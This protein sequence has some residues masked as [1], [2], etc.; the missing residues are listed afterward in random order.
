MSAYG[1]ADGP[2]EVT[3]EGTFS[4]LDD[5]KHLAFGWASVVELNG[6]PVV[7]RQGDYI[8]PDDIET[9][10]YE[11]VHKSRVGG[12][13]HRRNGEAPH[14]VS[15]LVESI[16]FTDDKVAKMGLPASFP[17]G[18]WVGYKIHDEDTWQMVKKGER[19]GFSI[20][21]KGRRTETDSR[22]LVGR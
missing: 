18:W 14:H 20:H 13:M 17:R 12:D 11:Y 21:G 9:A 22:E 1:K 4:K 5:D 10:A 7:D 19:T 8:S 3:W 15:D 6:E 2:V 16:V